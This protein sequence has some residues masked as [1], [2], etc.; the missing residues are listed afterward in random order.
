MTP[1]EKKKKVESM[2][3]RLVEA[4]GT[5]FL[6]IGRKRIPVADRRYIIRYSRERNRTAKKLGYPVLGHREYMAMAQAAGMTVPQS[7]LATVEPRTA[8]NGYQTN[9]PAV[10]VNS[11]HARRRPC[12]WI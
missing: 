10:Y 2:T 7:V 6:V 1:E 8:G 4:H 3:N 11:L 12:R 5:G 9:R